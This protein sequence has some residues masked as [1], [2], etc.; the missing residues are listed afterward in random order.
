M[1]KAVYSYMD[2]LFYDWNVQGKIIQLA[3][4]PSEKHYQY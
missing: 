1:I 4:S 3:F 2:S